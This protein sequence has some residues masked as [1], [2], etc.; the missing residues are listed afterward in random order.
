[1]PILLE[2]CDK[3]NTYIKFL[4]TLFTQNLFFSYMC[5]HPLFQPSVFSSFFLGSALLYI[6]KIHYIK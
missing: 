5:F 3:Q 1:M 6:W 4:S 2:Y